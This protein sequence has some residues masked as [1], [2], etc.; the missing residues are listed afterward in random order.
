MFLFLFLTLYMFRAHRAH[1]QER[2][3]VPTQPLVTATNHNMMHSQQ[4][5]KPIILKKKDH[6]T[7]ICVQVR[8]GRPRSRNS[9]LILRRCV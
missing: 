2:Q 7:I 5:V 6:K 1:H 4:N 3:I 9:V 8:A